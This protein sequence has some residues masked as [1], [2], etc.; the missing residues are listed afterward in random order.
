M[1]DTEKKERCGREARMDLISF[2]VRED[3]D[4]KDVKK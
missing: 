2:P 4:D 3:K 1:W